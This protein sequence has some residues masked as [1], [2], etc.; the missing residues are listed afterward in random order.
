MVGEVA[1]GAG[2]EGIAARDAATED[3]IGRLGRLGNGSLG[4][5]ADKKAWVCPTCRQSVGLVCHRPHS[6]EDSK[7]EQGRLQVRKC[8]G[9]GKGIKHERG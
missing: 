1:A 7:L 5:S 2:A 3:P 9:G 4:K 8:R 6:L